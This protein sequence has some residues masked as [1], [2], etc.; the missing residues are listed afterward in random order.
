MSSL[1][2]Y[3]QE[4]KRPACI[5][6]AL[7]LELREQVDEGFRN[8]VAGLIVKQW[9]ETQNISLGTTT[10]LNHKSRGHHERTDLGTRATGTNR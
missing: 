3:A 4:R 5:V 8:G 7:P 2:E 6:C 1:A 10:L 9:L